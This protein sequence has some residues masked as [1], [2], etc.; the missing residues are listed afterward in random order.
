MPKL[1]SID[2][3]SYAAFALRLVR[4]KPIDLFSA[5]SLESQESYLTTRML[6]YNKNVTLQTFLSITRDFYRLDSTFAQLY[7]AA[8]SPA[9][10]LRTAG[11]LAINSGWS[12]IRNIESAVIYH[13]GGQSHG[14]GGQ[15][16]EFV[17]I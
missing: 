4:C 17:V 7:N 9:S 8:A 11:S 1:V 13:H 3:E 12:V 15:K 6:P 10:R 16:V 2:D 5:T 14:D